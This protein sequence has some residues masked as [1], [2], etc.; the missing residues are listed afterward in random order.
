MED[1]TR[2]WHYLEKYISHSDRGMQMA[3]LLIQKLP[4]ELAAIV[5]EWVDPCDACWERYH[6]LPGGVT[7]DGRCMI[8]KYQVYAYECMFCKASTPLG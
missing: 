7:R 8:C 5:L 4:L 3:E 6:A 2:Y 1:K